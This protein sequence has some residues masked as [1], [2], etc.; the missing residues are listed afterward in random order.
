[1][2]AAPIN[3]PDLP[4][5]LKAILPYR[6]IIHSPINLSRAASVFVRGVVV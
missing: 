6:R 2:P 1:M 5:V 4:S 3:L